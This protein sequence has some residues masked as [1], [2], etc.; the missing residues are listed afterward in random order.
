MTENWMLPGAI[1]DTQTVTA[2]WEPAL[3]RPIDGV[4]VREVR[5]V[6]KASGS[7]TELYRRDWFDDDRPVDQV[8]HVVLEPGRVSAWHAHAHTWDR[9]F[10][11]SGMARLVLFDHREGSPTF[12]VVNELKIG[13]LRPTLV[14]VPPRVWHGVQCLGTTPAHLVNAVDRAYDYEHPDH[15]RV[16]EDCEAV[17]FRFPR[18]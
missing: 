15:W 7:L 4:V 8:F 9:L 10:V 13:V 1:P 16:P 5:H 11:T 3:L 18:G 17:P 14:V 6:P 12:G 2:R